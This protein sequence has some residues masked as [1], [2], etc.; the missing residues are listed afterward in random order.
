MNTPL[1]LNVS[2]I[3]CNNWYKLISFALNVV[4]IGAISKVTKVLKISKISRHA[5]LNT[6]LGHRLQVIGWRGVCID[7]HSSGR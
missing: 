2:L 6:F 7:A 1:R 3:H 4:I 5:G